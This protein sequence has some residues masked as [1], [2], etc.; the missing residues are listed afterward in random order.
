MIGL[1]KIN[2][3]LYYLSNSHTINKYIMFDPIKSH[4]SMVQNCITKPD[5]WHIWL[6]HLSYARL[7]L[8]S[9]LDPFVKFTLNHVCGV[10]P[11]AKQKSLPFNVS[12]TVSNKFFELI[13]CDIWGPFS[14]ISHS[15]YKFSLTII[16]NHTRFTWLFLMKS[17]ANT[18]PLLNYFLTY[19]QTHFNIKLQTIITNNGQEF[20]MPNFYQQH[21]IIQQIPCIETP[22]QNVIV[23]RKHQHLLNV[24]RSL[25]FQSNLPQS[26]MCLNNYISY[27]SN[28]FNFT[29]KSYTIW[30][31]IP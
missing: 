13:H 17:K 24:A 30:A 10:C 21:G 1:V 25:L 20:N 9:S 11:L 4:S 12:N 26:W 6:G 7:Q 3:G 18:R 8:I 28:P 5:I 19:V 16:D 22:Q 23:E 2:S 15:G 31:V 29:Q 27:Q 14:I